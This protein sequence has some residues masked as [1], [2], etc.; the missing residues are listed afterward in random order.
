[1]GFLY[2]ILGTAVSIG[3]I[4]ILRRPVIN[5]IQDVAVF[6]AITA[7]RALWKISP[8]IARDITTGVMDTLFNNTRVWAE[9][10]NK[11]SFNPL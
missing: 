10:V 6:L 8:K 4:S 1:M 9:I 3:L 7:N 11:F 2:W 5:M